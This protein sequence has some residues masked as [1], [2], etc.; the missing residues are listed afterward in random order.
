MEYVE[1]CKLRSK[2][3][4]MA[5]TLA[6]LEKHLNEMAFDETACTH[7]AARMAL[8]AA[9]Q[10]GQTFERIEAGFEDMA[11]ACAPEEPSTIVL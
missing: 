7:E 4:E 2:V 3:A 10:A 1:I 11:K 5:D 6:A 8:C 9:K